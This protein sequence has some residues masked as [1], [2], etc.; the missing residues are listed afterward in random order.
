MLIFPL[1][2][3]LFTVNI[4]TNFVRECY[5]MVS[6]V[7]LA[8]LHL[9]VLLQHRMLLALSFLLLSWL[10]VAILAG[11]LLV[12]ALLWMLRKRAIPPSIS[13]TT[14][15]NT[16]RKSPP[17]VAVVIPV[18]NEAHVL[19]KSIGILLEY[20][21]EDFPYPAHIIIAEN[22]STDG[23]EII[24]HRLAET[25]EDVRVIALSQRGR[26]RALRTAWSQSQADI[27]AY[28]DVDL[29]TELRALESLCRGIHEEGYDIATGSR[30]LPASQTTRCLKR[31]VLSRVYNMMVKWVLWTHFSDAQCGFKAVSRRV[32]ESV[33][34]LIQNQH[35]F[36]DTELLV[37]GEKLGFKIKDVPV[38][39][40][41]DTDSRVKI[42]ATVWEDIREVCRLRW[43][44]W[45][46][47]PRLLPRP[48]PVAEPQSLRQEGPVGTAPAKL[49]SA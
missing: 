19:E 15:T 23:T 12:V 41:E 37:L 49:P 35:W 38:R 11:G 36:F 48:T 7:K 45:T 43:L 25:Y 3:L 27:V 34:P 17:T 28:M 20:L 30:L 46:G 22:G 31:E 39:W 8:T 13:T 6:L 21:R 40:I 16:A 4:P 32:V 1:A 26:G 33:I 2:L 5:S 29:S 42:V 10:V 9:D 18:L 44:L 47:Q 14:T 24:A